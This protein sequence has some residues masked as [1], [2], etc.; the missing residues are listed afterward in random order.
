MV[1][2]ADTRDVMVRGAADLLRRRGYS[3]TGFREVIASTGA[4]RGSIYHHFP[5]G[6]AQLAEEAV[7]WAGEAFGAAVGD[8]DDPRTALRT[9]GRFFAAEL[10]RKDFNVGCPVVAVAVED[11]DGDDGPRDAAGEVFATWQGRLAA[12]LQDAG[13][14]EGRAL[15]VAALSVAAIEGAVVLCRAQRSVAPLE[16][17]LAELDAVVVGATSG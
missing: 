2:R 9:F 16:A 15:R 10:E 6:K 14:D 17:T 8:A 4:P 12:L 7:R 1:K 11:H 13:A 5:R 3:G